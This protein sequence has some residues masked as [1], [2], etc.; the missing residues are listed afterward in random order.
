V[1]AGARESI[2]AVAGISDVKSKILERVYE[3]IQKTFK[4]ANKTDYRKQFGAYNEPLYLAY[5]SNI[6]PQGIMAIITA[7]ETD[8]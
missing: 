5:P 6:G 7:M 4:L 3:G 8:S 2:Q 1:Q